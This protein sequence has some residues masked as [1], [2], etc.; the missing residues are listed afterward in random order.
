MVYFMTVTLYTQI[1][2]SFMLIL[3]CPHAIGQKKKWA[4]EKAVMYTV[5]GFT[6]V[7]ILCFTFTQ[8]V[9]ELKNYI[10]RV[11]LQSGSTSGSSSTS[12][13]TRTSTSGR[14]SRKRHFS[15]LEVSSCLELLPHA[16][17]KKI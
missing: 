8:Q 16:G 12:G 6:G 13:S 7:T 11:E 9:R 14:R 4:N 15:D 1:Q 2:G 17:I 5:F 10:L 3:N